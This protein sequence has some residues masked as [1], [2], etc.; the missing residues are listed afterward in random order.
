M[1]QQ[2]IRDVTVRPYGLGR[3]F[4]RAAQ[5]LLF[6]GALLLTSGLIAEAAAASNPTPWLSSQ[7]AKFTIP[8]DN[9][10]TMKWT[11]NLWQIA[12][13]G[14]QTLVGTDTATSGTLSIAVPKTSTCHF[15]VDLYRGVHYYSGYQKYITSCGTSSTTSSSSSSTSS[16]PP[17][18]SKPTPTT[19][20]PKTSGGTG[21]TPTSVATKSGGSPSTAGPA[22]KPA[23]STTVSPGELAFTGVGI[24]M[25]MIAAIGALLLLVGTALLLY[26]RRYP[27]TS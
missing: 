24:G 13:G 11:L 3:N 22:T 17:T 8:A 6:V 18:T 21:G 25:W 1:A 20:K 16:S 5:G 27:K 12:S 14:H 10:P 7:R 9:P 19:S 26:V 2:T 4:R 23:T 15:Q